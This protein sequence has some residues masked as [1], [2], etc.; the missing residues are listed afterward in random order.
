[1]TASRWWLNVCA[2]VPLLAS[3]SC[4]TTAARDESG[5]T[6]TDAHGD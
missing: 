4:G 1:V 2:H 3:H 6:E 5:Y